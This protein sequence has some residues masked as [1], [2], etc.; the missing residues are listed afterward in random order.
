MIERQYEDYDGE[1]WINIRRDP[2]RCCGFVPVGHYPARAEHFMQCK[3]APSDGSE[4][5]SK[6]GRKIARQEVLHW[7]ED[8]LE[9]LANVL[10][11]IMHVTDPRR[12]ISPNRARAFAHTIAERALLRIKPAK[13]RSAHQT[14]EKH[15]T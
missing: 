2:N 15:G 1:K 9:D 11:S 12:D 13:L 5:C 3:F 6:H 14:G 7:D 10:E 8:K 4:F